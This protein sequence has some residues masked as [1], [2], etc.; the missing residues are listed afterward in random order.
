MFTYTLSATS[1]RMKEL[2]NL[3]DF[4]DGFKFLTVTSKDHPAI[5]DV[6]KSK[7]LH[8]K[9]HMEGLLHHLPSAEALKFD[10]T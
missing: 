2:L 7:N 9:N 6:I 4:S 1:E 3:F 10:L 5:L 8:L